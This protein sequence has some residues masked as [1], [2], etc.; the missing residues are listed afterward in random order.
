MTTKQRIE[1]YNKY[2]G[3]CTYCGTELTLKTMQIDHIVPV[4]RDI[5]TNVMERPQLH[6]IDNMNPSCR[7]CNG[8]KHSNSL[9]GWREVLLNRYNKHIEYL[10][11]SKTKQV[12]AENIGVI[13]IKQ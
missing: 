10:F 6:I 5:T 11:K 1:V 13:T 7:Y 9:E 12:I 2:G 4:L 8:D 3:R